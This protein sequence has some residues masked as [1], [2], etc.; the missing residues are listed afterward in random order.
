MKKSDG[1]RQTEDGWYESLT[2]RDKTEYF[3]DSKSFDVVVKDFLAVVGNDL[4]QE[5]NDFV[6]KLD[7]GFVKHTLRA[8]VE[9]TP[10]YTSVLERAENIVPVLYEHLKLIEK[11]MLF[12][13]R[14]EVNDSIAKDLYNLDEL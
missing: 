11:R 6:R 14:M 2:P 10:S 5:K 7:K 9:Y 4:S 3:F 13:L 1:Y 12:I 8:M